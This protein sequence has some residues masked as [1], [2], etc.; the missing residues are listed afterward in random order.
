MQKDFV[1]VPRDKG[2]GKIG[3]IFKRFYAF[4]RAKELGLNNKSSTDTYNNAGGISTKYIIDKNIR[5]S[6]IK[7]SIYNILTENH[8]L[9]NTYWMS[10]MHK[11]PVKAAFIIASPKS[12]IKPFAR[13]ITSILDKYKHITIK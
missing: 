8:Q 13:T 1:F 3:L 10:K 7:F 11:N 4:V 9:P 5:D 6:K 12:S 2:T